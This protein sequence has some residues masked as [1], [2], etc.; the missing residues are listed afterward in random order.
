MPGIPRFSD[1]YEERKW[2]KEHMAAVGDAMS[3]DF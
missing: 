3:G 1:A 2:A